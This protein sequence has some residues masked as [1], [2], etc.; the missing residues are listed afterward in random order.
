M[1][2]TLQQLSQNLLFFLLVLAEQEGKPGAYLAGI[3]LCL[4]KQSHRLDRI[5]LQVFWTASLLKHSGKKV[6]GLALIVLKTLGVKLL[7]KNVK[8]IKNVTSID[9]FL[10]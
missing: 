8:N 7:M 4:Y 2:Y 5:V 10:T 1:L 3:G 9:S 6:Y